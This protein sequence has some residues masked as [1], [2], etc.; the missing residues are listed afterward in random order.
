MDHDPAIAHE[1]RPAG[2]PERSRA[3]PRSHG[4]RGMNPVLHRELRA[5]ARSAHPWVMRCTTAALSGLAFWVMSGW[6]NVRQ[7]GEAR[8]FFIVLNGAATLVLG[9]A[10]IWLTHDVIARERRDGTLGLLML[11][12]LTAS[13]V[14][15]GKASSAVIEVLSAWWSMLPMLVLPLMLGGVRVLDVAVMATLQGTVMA[16][17]VASGLAASTWSTAAGWA[18]FVGCGILIAL[19]GFVVLPVAVLAYSTTGGDWVAPALMATLSAGVVLAMLKVAATEL[20][21][22]WEAGRAGGDLMKLPTLPTPGGDTADGGP[23][24]AYDHIPV[25][26][27]TGWLERVAA[28]RRRRLLETN[29]LAWLLL[30]RR[31]A[32]W[33]VPVGMAGVY[34]WWMTLVAG[35]ASPR[36]PEWVIPAVMSLSMAG[37]L[38]EEQANGMLEVLMTTPCAGL[39]ERAMCRRLWVENGTW[40]ALHA[41]LTALIAPL[42]EGGTRWGFLPLA[43]AVWA[44]PWITLRVTRITTRWWTRA[45]LGWVL[46]QKLPDV[47]GHVLPAMAA[48]WVHDR[49]L[50]FPE[51]WLEMSLKAAAVLGVA[52]WARPRERRR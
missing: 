25:A 12:P 4:G 27:A 33:M 34:V 6:F 49:P 2:H 37:W 41:V 39:V 29:P 28:E 35:E 5:R 30:R 21:H 23:T 14:L 9:A 50:R 20:R 24:H 40:V 18:L 51:G 45:L 3:F 43:A 17:S 31:G 15:A 19:G 36:W 44:S 48:S 42:A 16:L 47:V 1:V 22:A 32:L 13:Q 46:V 10:G 52:W 38:R 11:S 26:H 7:P 8:D